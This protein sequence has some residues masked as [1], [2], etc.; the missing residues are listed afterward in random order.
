[1]TDHKHRQAEYSNPVPSIPESPQNSAEIT[2]QQREQKELQ[3]KF[4]K[5]GDAFATLLRVDIGG[6]LA[7][8]GDEGFVGDA[9]SLY[10]L[11]DMPVGQ[12]NKTFLAKMGWGE[13]ARKNFE[14]NQYP[15]FSHLP[16]EVYV[17][18]Q[19]DSFFAE[20]E[21]ARLMQENPAEYLKKYAVFRANNGKVTMLEKRR[22]ERAAAEIDPS[23][24]QY[25]DLLTS[26]RNLII[27]YRTTPEKF[28]AFL[29]ELP[30]DPGKLGDFIK[31]L[32]N[33]PYL[34][35]Q[36]RNDA[37]P[38][39]LAMDDKKRQ[40]GLMLGMGINNLGVA[41]SDPRAMASVLEL[42]SKFN[43]ETNSFLK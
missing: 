3:A 24:M 38:N 19:S 30:D 21:Q 20:G 2:E 10:T 6:S 13:F 23:S 12:G 39:L 37:D 4:K 9:A 1:M 15:E 22:G 8:F 18:G 31:E 7:R 11:V 40:M 28:A 14:T 33:R 43:F 26:L 25:N 17:V 16:F 35:W 29:K 36:Q 34:T 32:F 42:K 27:T 41:A 5:L